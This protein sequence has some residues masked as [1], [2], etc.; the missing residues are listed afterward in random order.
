MYRALDPRFTSVANPDMLQALYLINYL[1]AM[2]SAYL[3]YDLQQ[4]RLKLTEIWVW[5]Q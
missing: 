3:Q 5:Q 2:Y 4:Q 1:K